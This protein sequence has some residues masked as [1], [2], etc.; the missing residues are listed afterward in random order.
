[1]DMRKYF[2]TGLVILLP[3]ALTL[4]IVVFIFNL[5]TTPFLGM[6]KAVF[7]HYDLFAGG[8]FLLKADQL[9]NLVAQCLILISLFFIV[10]GLG[11][12]ARWFFFKAF[13]K[14]ADYVV[15]HIPLVRSIYQTCQDII[16]TIF[17]SNANSFKQVVLAR[18][19][20]PHIYSIGFI[21]SENT[22]HLMGTVDAETVIVFVPTTPNP[23]SGFMLLFKSSDLIYLDMKVEDAFKYVISCGV[24][25]P[26]FNAISKEE[27]NLV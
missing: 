23:T 19:P 27:E 2:I 8:F 12:I 13:I 22:T 4:T 15:K 7:E 9:Q 16:K 3:L 10:L 1:M 18:F 5:L 21:T 14:F 6:V 20:N 17:S 24:V 11:F 25:A 26:P